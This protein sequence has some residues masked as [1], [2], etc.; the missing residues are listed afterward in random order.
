[1]SENHSREDHR[2]ENPD[3]SQSSLEGDPGSAVPTEPVHVDAPADLTELVEEYDVVLADFYADWCGPCQM[4]EPVV[5]EIAA[6]TGAV[7]AKVD[8]DQ[9]QHLAAEYGVQGVPTLFLFAGGEPVQ[10]LV[11]MQNAENLRNLIG[12]YS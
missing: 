9:H 4:L 1:M 12:N 3:E 7:V 10:R 5:E 8:V 2:A 6:T 11:G